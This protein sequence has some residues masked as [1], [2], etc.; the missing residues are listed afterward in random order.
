M[1]SAFAKADQAIRSAMDHNAFTAACLLAGRHD[2]ILHRCAYGRL[3]I[4]DD[5]PLTNE[6]TL[7]DLDSLTKPLTVGLITLRAVESGTLC[8]WDQLGTFLNAPEDKQNITIGQLLTH[9][10]GFPTGIHLWERA[11]SMEDAA[12]VLLHTPLMAPPGARVHYC[13]AGYILLGQLLECL[14][15]TPLDELAAQEVFRPLRMSRT[16]YLPADGNIA[17]TEMQD[18]GR[19]LQGLVHDENAQFLGGVS[20]NAGL[21]STMDDVA[22]A[23]QMLSTEGQLPDGT[24]Y[25]SR[26]SVRLALQSRTPGM[27]QER[28]LLFDLPALHSGFTGDLFPAQT[29]GHTGFTG[30]SMALDPQSGLY[31]VFLTN[32]VCPSRDSTDIYRVRRLIHNTVYAAA[33][34]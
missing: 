31:V 13:C 17:A 1:L 4:D 24:Q 25:L 5:A 20:G 29:V 21:F 7:F 33:G 34:V 8:L 26:A 28:S 18:D 32:R 23:L 27:A 19:C 14:Y 11:R 6:H 22:L 15:Q 16:G 3:S 30:C 12:D 9:T 2:R 10:A